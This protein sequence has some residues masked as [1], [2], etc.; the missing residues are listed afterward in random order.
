MIVMIHYLTGN[1]FDSDAMALV[2]TVNLEGV[3]GKGVALQFRNRFPE[4]YRVYRTAC[5]NKSIDIGKLLIHK[6]NSVCGEMIIIN[7]PT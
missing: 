3:M 7:F 5:K 2:N 6:E 4:N 1:I